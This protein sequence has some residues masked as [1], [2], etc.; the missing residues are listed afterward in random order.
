MKF[1]AK[2]S[3][4]VVFLIV[5]I[6]NAVL[7]KGFNIENFGIRIAVSAFFAVLISP[8]KKKILTPTGEKTQITWFLLKEPIIL[9]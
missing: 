2:K 9:D 6:V 4:I 3:F 5:F 8:R 1:L 7:D